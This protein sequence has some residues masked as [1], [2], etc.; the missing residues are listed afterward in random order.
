MNKNKLKVYAPKAREKF[1]KAVSERAAL[2]GITEE[3]IEPCEIKGDYAFISGKPFPKSI[4]KSRN[5]LIEKIESKGFTQVM[6]EVA[7]TWFNR[8][9]A[10]RFMELNGYLTH[11]YRV[12]SHPEGHSEPEILEKAHYLEKLDGL[13]KREII[14]LKTAGNKDAELY[15]KLIIAQCNEL[16]GAMPFLFEKVDDPTELLLPDNLL[17]TDS[18]IRQMVEAISEEDWKEV[19]IIGWLYQFY[20]SEKKDAL[21]K[22]KKAYKTEDIPAVTQLFTPN[23]IVKYLVQNSLGAKWLGTYPASGIK[24]KMEYYIEPAEQ[25]EEVK[26]K[27]KEITPDSLN[28]EELTVMDPA[29]GSGHILVE[30]YNLLTEIYLERGYRP[31]E[32]PSLILTKNLYGLEIDHR[33]AQLAGFALM[34]KARQDDR[35]IFEKQ[36]KPNVAVLKPASD[37]VQGR[38]ESEDINLLIDLFE[39][40][41]TFGSLIR[42]PEEL[43]PK[44]PSIKQELEYKRGDLNSHDIF[45]GSQYY[46]DLLGLVRQVEMLSKRYD[47][48]IANPPYM[49]GKGMNGKLKEFAKTQYPSTKSD[50]FAMFIERGFE[51]AKEKIGYN[52]MV[53][54]QSWMFLSS[55][56]QMRLTLVNTTTIRNMVHMSN[57]VMGIAFGTC[58]TVWTGFK[59]YAHKGSFSYVDYSDLNDSCVPKEFPIKNDRL[60]YASSNDFKKIPGSP[61]AY[62]VSDRVRAV[63]RKGKPVGQVALPR[64]GNTTTDNNRFLRFWVE[65]NMQKCAIGYSSSVNVAKDNSKWVPYNKGGGFRKWYGFNEYLVNWYD[66][67]S[68]IRNIPHSVIANEQFFFEPGLTWSTVTSGQFSIRN[69]GYGF[70]FDNGGCCVFGERKVLSGLLGFMN[71]KV[72][73]ELFSEINP[74]LN[75]QSGDVCRIPFINIHV[76]SN[77]D[78]ITLVK[79][80]RIDWDSHETSWDF[81]DLSILQAENK[82]ST[83]DESYQ[84]HR[85]QCRKMTEEMKHLEE[86][87][88]RVFIEAYGLQDELTPDVP[89][90]EIT[91]F[92]NPKYRYKGEL[93]DEGLEARFRVDT[94]KELISYS[95]G[96]MMGRYSLDKPGLIY[97][98]SGNEGFDASQYETFPADDDG[99]IPITEHEWFDD[100]AACRFFRFIETVWDK[101]GLDSN[102]DFI[103][104]AIG[105][106]SGESSRD[107]I[108]RYFV[109]DFYRDHCQTYKKRPIY[110][111]FTSG[112]EKAFQALV[113]LHRYNE[114]TLSRMRTEYVLPLQTKI[115]RYS[116]HLEK[117]KDNATSTSAANKIQREITSLLKQRDELIKFDEHLRHYADMKIK[118]DLDDGVKVNYGKFGNLLANTQKITGKGI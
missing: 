43:I 63:F 45:T 9:A 103:A 80:S 101:K 41:S 81:K 66:N 21:M 92:A 100:D 15:R 73:V 70:V 8:F 64:K 6:E 106:K 89:I 47:C 67:G 28:P 93:T 35:Q 112:K 88:N 86:E 110:W 2:Y 1:I 38:K 117:D 68:E 54:M 111:L 16:Y 115:A 94:M 24:E 11:G 40:A 12:L 97:A 14:S 26:Q 39:D 104:E 32:I 30:A 78:D 59:M 113:Y 91:L 34:M 107:T 69:F 82:N 3:K 83:V 116:E 22:A 90:K 4:E 29:C 96:C 20:I 85:N 7:Y 5:K 49:G 10:I 50:L 56:E 71:S 65:V 57:G 79:L 109:N 18:I 23:W 98:H 95:V 72:F 77:P 102:L 36:I 17:N 37:R 25:S 42:V 55:Y 48:V 46:K 27:I 19:E 87:N 52:G 62:W 13:E 61:I 60:S 75:F 51:M 105:C 114:G 99:I 118:L 76:H 74:T 108:R 58:A 44:L 84:S 31:K 33:A 53:T